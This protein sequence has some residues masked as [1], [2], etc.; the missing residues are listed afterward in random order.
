MRLDRNGHPMSFPGLGQAIG[1]ARSRR[2]ALLVP[3]LV[4]AVAFAEPRPATNG[5][6]LSAARVPTSEILGGGPK[7]DAVRSVDEPRFVTSAEAMWVGP[8]DPVVSV[9]VD[10]TTH[11]HPVHL[12]EYHQIVNDRIGDKPVVLT[13][14]PLAGVPRAFLAEVG[15]TRLEFGVPGLVRNHN[16]LLY[17][18][19]TESLW[20]QITGAAISGRHAGARLTPLRVRQEPLA[21]ALARSPRAKVLAPPTP[22]RH[23]YSISPFQRY[24]QTN[25]GLFPLTAQD[26]RFHL[27]ELVLGVRAGGKSRAY[28]GSLATAAGGEV[29]DSFQG[30]AIRFRYDTET[31]T[32][33]YDVPEAVE[34]IEAYWLAW[35]AWFPDTEIWHDPG[36]PS[37]P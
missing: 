4:A 5:F 12:L 22:P 34:V 32:F 28:L 13:Y 1:P 26:K 8:D 27:K 35:K 24:W 15:G 21:A 10:E 14:D 29:E 18:R 6:D 31:G 19:A 25:Q 17:D 30:H 7:R 16:F 2:L 20:Q 23:D 11:L 9:T 36:S 3:W 37:E 33:R